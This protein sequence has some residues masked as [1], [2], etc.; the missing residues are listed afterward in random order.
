[1][2]MHKTDYIAWYQTHKVLVGYVAVGLVC[3]VL[4]LILG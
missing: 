4:G 2:S 3:F 1:M